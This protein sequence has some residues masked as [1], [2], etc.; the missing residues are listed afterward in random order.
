VSTFLSP[1]KDKHQAT[2]KT[3]HKGDKKSI[4]LKPV[5]PPVKI[6]DNSNQSPNSD[7]AIGYMVDGYQSSNNG[8]IFNAGYISQGG[9]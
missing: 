6:R 9:I 4:I 5:K 2:T 3:E 7:K 8:Q 1:I